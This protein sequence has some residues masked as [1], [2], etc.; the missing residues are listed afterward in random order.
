M[1]SSSSTNSSYLA[2]PKNCKKTLNSTSWERGLLSPVLQV[3]LV[4]RFYATACFQSIVGDLIGVDSSTA[5]CTIPRVTDTLM[6]CVRDWIKMLTHAQANHQK[7][8]FYAI[9]GLPRG[10][11]SVIGCFDGTHI[12]I[13]GPNQQEHEFVNW[14]NYHS[15]NVQVRQYCFTTQSVYWYNF[16]HP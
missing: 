11:P 3:C 14:K 13:Q 16:T 1:K 5:C 10:L 12:R 4:L 7:Q 8:K 2:W 6:L 9:R 15:I